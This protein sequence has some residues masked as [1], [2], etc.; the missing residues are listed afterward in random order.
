MPSRY[1]PDV[2]KGWARTFRRAF[3]LWIEGRN[4]RAVASASAPRAGNAT[5]FGG[6]L[7]GFGLIAWTPW[8]QA[9]LTTL[10]HP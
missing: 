10:L 9:I 1:D 7:L 4:E 6:P 8:G 3:L 5:K 2:D